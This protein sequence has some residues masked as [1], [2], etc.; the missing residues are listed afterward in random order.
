MSCLGSVAYDPGTA[1]TH[2]TTAAAAAMTALDTTNLR[3]TFTAPASGNVYVRMKGCI[4]GS[5]PYPQLLFGILQG[6][7]VIARQ[8]PVGSR[9]AVSASERVGLEASF[10][11]TGLV[12]GNSYTWDAAVGVELGVASSAVKYGGPND[13]TNDNAFGA[14]TVEVYDTPAL[15]AAVLYDPATA[16]NYSTASRIVMTAFD[17]SNLRLPITAPASGKVLWRLRAAMDGATTMPSVLIGVM[18]G[19]SILSRVAPPCGM[20]A[21]AFATTRIVYEAGGVITGLSGAYNLDAAYGVEVLLASTAIRAG[22][23]NNGTASDAWGAV[24]FEAWA[25]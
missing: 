23:P 19:A 14:F 25:A 17:T 7:S 18:S 8:C 3:V 24:S 1:D 2:F 12:A 10:V 11:V 9:Q 5:T 21:G 13:T 22:G 16:V 6:A 4:H 15:L 20:P